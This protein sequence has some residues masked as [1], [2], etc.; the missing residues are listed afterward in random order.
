MPDAE[1]PDAPSWSDCRE[2]LKDEVTLGEARMRNRELPRAEFAA[3]PQDDVEVEDSRSP[4]AAAPPAKVALKG[5]QASKH[6]LRV[7][8]AFNQR[9][10]V[11]EIASGAAMGRIE[12]DRRSI[13][14]AEFL[15]EPG[16]RRLRHSRRSPIA[17]VRSV[18]P[19][20]DGIEI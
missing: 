8:V 19:D 16:D 3:A 14:Q 15:V 10:C 4:A 9:N 7:E 17:P 2:R 18:R 13:E 5:L 12:N 6:L 11:G 20:G 1:L